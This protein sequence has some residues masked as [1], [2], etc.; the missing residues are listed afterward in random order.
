METEEAENLSH[1]ALILNA[2]DSLPLN[3]ESNVESSS[4]NGDEALVASL[5][6]KELILT[7]F[8]IE[9][10]QLKE[11]GANDKAA[12]TETEMLSDD[13]RD[14][15]TQ[16]PSSFSEDLHGLKGTSGMLVKELLRHVPAELSKTPEAKGEHTEE[17][18][19]AMTLES[20]TL[21]NVMEGFGGLETEALLET[22]NALEEEAEVL[23]KEEE[24]RVE[25]TKEDVVVYEDTSEEDIL[26]LD[27]ISEATDAIEAETAVMLE[28]ILG[29]KQAPRQ[30]EEWQNGES[31]VQEAEKE[32]VEQQGSVLEAMAEVE[33]SLETLENESLSETT[34][35]LEREADSGDVEDM[36]AT[37][38]LKMSEDL[39]IDVL[40]EERF[41]S[42]SGH[43]EGVGPV[44]QEEEME[45]EETQTGALSDEDASGT[46]ADLDPVQRLFLEK[47]REY[48]NMHRLYGGGDLSSFPLFSFSGEREL[49]S[50]RKLY[51][52]HEM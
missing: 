16:V 5:K 49:H 17:E 27:S 36:E 44:G 12:V 26:T 8:F 52:M 47:I 32:S 21:A 46:H 19:E 34:D 39:Q 3:N 1:A 6:N 43:E 45:E 37:E 25:T 50:Q 24:M 14:V 11:I 23:A 7:T 29:L 13:G 40:T 42:V 22:R 15:L 28:A 48:N 20:I 33:A 9:G 31:I 38:T 4:V 51:F 2:Q 30:Q 41:I 35:N 10:E 18:E